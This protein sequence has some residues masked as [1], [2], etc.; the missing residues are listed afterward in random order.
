VAA[1]PRPAHNSTLL[2]RNL[3][4]AAPSEGPP[5]RPA[6]ASAKS[7]AAKPVALTQDESDESH[8]AAVGDKPAGAPTARTIA[9][10]PPKSAA[11]ANAPVGN[12]G[13]PAVAPV[14]AQAQAAKASSNAV[15]AT[16][17]PTKKP[18]AVSAHANDPVADPAKTA[19]P[20]SALTSAVATE[21]SKGKGRYAL[22]LG[23]FPD[24]A[25]ADAFA[26]RFGAASPFVISAEVPG[27]GLWYRVRVGDYGSQKEAVAA[28]SDFEKEYNSIAY[29]VGP[30]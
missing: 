18:A 6:A 2:P 24:R 23:A 3:F 28:K 26:K 25:Q 16:A 29:V 11:H 19:A 30:R 1:N 13:Q 27:K 20:K 5:E 15:L 4:A 12:K 14:A 9:A 8:T 22:Q 17:P 10:T 21:T 7:V